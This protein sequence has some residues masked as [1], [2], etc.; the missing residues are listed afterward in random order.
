[1]DKWNINSQTATAVARLAVALAVSLLAMLGVEIDGDGIENA[2]LAVAS[3]AVMAWVWWKNNN[4]TEAAQEAQAVLDAIRR[5]ADEGREAEK[6]LAAE[7]AEEEF[8]E[9]SDCAEGA[10]RSE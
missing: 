3:V 8:I 1:M 4:V 10:G 7:A 9:K 6:R 5:D 2:V